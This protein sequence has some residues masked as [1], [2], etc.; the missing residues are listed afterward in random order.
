ML[1]LT[2]Q[3]RDII[4]HRAGRAVVFAVAGSGKTSTIVRRIGELVN[5][6]CHRPDRILATTFGREAKRQLKDKLALQP[7]CKEVHALTLSQLASKIVRFSDE[8]KRLPARIEADSGMLEKCFSE[9]RKRMQNGD[10]VNHN[11]YSPEYIDF[12]KV[13]DLGWDD[14]SKYV[15]E[16]K[17]DMLLTKWSYDQLDPSCHQIFDIK[18]FKDA[19]WLEVL[20]DTYDDE[21]LKRKFFGYSDIMQ[22]STI[23]LTSEV[24]TYQHFAN[25]YDY[26][27][28]DEYQDVNRAQNTMLMKLDDQANNMMVIGD[29][30][31]TIYEWRGARPTFIRD[32]LDDNQWQTFFLDRNFRCSPG[33]ILLAREV[34][35]QNTNRAA[36]KM[37]PAKGFTGQL[38]VQRFESIGKQAQWIVDL[39]EESYQ[40]SS[41]TTEER[42]YDNAVVLI[43]QYAETPIIEEEL[44]SK[45]IPY[46]IPGSRPFYYRPEF[47]L[48]ESYLRLAELEI[49]RSNGLGLTNTES[50]A[51]S[52]HFLRIYIRPATFLRKTTAN[53]LLHQLQ[54]AQSEAKPIHAHLREIHGDILRD[55]G[56]SSNGILALAN[57]F[58]KCLQYGEDISAKQAIETLSE[59]VEIKRWFIESSVNE[60]AGEAR[61]AI[62]D[63]LLDYVRNDKLQQ[64]LRAIAARRELD[65]A[66][67]ATDARSRVKIL[68]VFKAKGLEFPRVIIPNLNATASQQS[69]A[70]MENDLDSLSEEQ[71]R[72]IYVA[73][74]RP[75]DDL[76][77][78][79]T[80]DHPSQS[81]QKANYGQLLKFLPDA[82]ALYQGRLDRVSDQSPAFFVAR[83]SARFVKFQLGPS[84]AKSWAETLTSEDQENLERKISEIF[85]IFRQEF[86]ALS[87]DD[88]KK[89]DICE[90]EWSNIAHMAREIRRVSSDEAIASSEDSNSI[91]DDLPTRLE[92]NYMKA[93]STGD[94]YIFDLELN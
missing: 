75:I 71:R 10:M 91:S 7:N 20:I 94:A 82:K 77:I 59:Q 17:N 13:R 40:S 53:H 35:E 65:A 87:T 76:F 49:K 85:S 61:A 14:F 84:C 23:V 52:N 16:L 72:I 86:T 83:L 51:F 15:D 32:K 4:S 81:L 50:E 57:Y 22:L 5:K 90:A 28:V 6:H 25:C 38:C 2:K 3:Q 89:V 56:R 41:S 31:Q 9:A 42:H 12:T 44:I 60:Q 43:R 39:I 11:G 68:T 47:R 93:P 54:T 73:L 18:Q 34:I 33:S 8:R 27:F 70:G 74:T 26:V 45:G 24:F 37:M 62:V 79:F 46:T 67:E 19:P 88:K 92:E 64:F 69:S 21:R 29:D 80:G 55:N 30:D 58:E 78:S 48:I 36:K 63:G 1:K 66:E